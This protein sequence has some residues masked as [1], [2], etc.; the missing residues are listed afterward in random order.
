MTAYTPQELAQAL[1]RCASEPIHQ[2][3]RIQPHGAMIVVDA[4]ADLR[5]LQ[6]SANL[7]SLL[8]LSE[9]EIPG[10]ALA[11]LLGEPAAAAVRSLVAASEGRHASHGALDVPSAG[12]LQARVFPADGHYALE[13]VSVAPGESPEDAAADIVRLQ[14]AL[15][16]IEEEHDPVRYLERIAG[17]VREASGFDRVMVYRFDA[18]WDGEVVAE[19]R[20]EGV[21]SYLGTRFPASDIP[22]QARRL[23]TQNRFRLVADVESQPVPLVPA[24]DPATGQPTDLTFSL[25][26]SFSPVHVEYLRNMGVKASMSISLLQ[27]GRLWGLVACHHMSTRNLSAAAQDTATRISQIASSRLS[28]LE[29]R[30]R[31]GLGEQ[32][33][34]TVG[35]LLKNINV[36]SEGAVLDLMKDRLLRLFD[37]TGLIVVIEGQV[38]A[39]GETPGRPAIDALLGWLGS[40][41]PEEVLACDDLSRRH[42]PAEAYIGTASGIMASP[43]TTGM[44][45]CMVWLRP[46]RLRAVRWAGNPEK[47]LEVDYAGHFQLSPRKSF[48]TWTENWRGRSDSWTVP[49]TEAAAIL[50]RALTEGMA[51]KAR[52]DQAREA[53]REVEHRYSLA[54]QA[55]NDGIW[56]WSVRAGTMIV[57]PAFGEMLGYAPDELG[58][59]FDELLPALLHPDERETVLAAIERQ[60]RET[61][62]HELEFRLRRRDGGYA[63]ILSRGT[64]LERD[65]AGSPAR[66]IGT[67]VDL[68]M[69]KR[70]EAELREA[71]D[72]AEAANL[73]KSHFL[74]NMS[75][76]LRTPLNGMIGL[77]ELA[78]RQVPEPKARDQ[79][80]RALQL[81]HQLS[82]LVNDILDVSRLESE[83]LVLETV[84]FDLEEALADVAS[85]T[86]QRAAA[87][88]LAF[89][90]DVAPAL[91]GRRFTGDPLRIGQVVGC[92]A[93]NGVKFTEQG[94][95][96]LRVR[97]ADDR[98]TAL[99][100]R[101]EVEDTGIG[102]APGDA[103]R[104]FSLFEQGDG[105]ST[106]K[107]GGTG[108]GL[109]LGKRL[110]DLMGG[111]IGVTSEEGKGSLFWFTVPLGVA[112]PV[113]PGAA[114]AAAGAAEIA[115]IGRAEG[116]P[117]SGGH[118][119][120]GPVDVPRLQE[121]CST[122]LPMIEAGEVRAQEFI[123][124]NGELLRSASPADFQQLRRALRRFD[125]EQAERLLRA[126][127]ERHGLGAGHG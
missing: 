45:N 87:K 77:T 37:A 33:G 1:E 102:I 3:G 68:T 105:S 92:L 83:R 97:L 4:G 116:A 107:H 54:L 112:Q 119:A 55:T 67:H 13:L 125:F 72:R 58:Q 127:M 78:R 117:E 11:A 120:A 19:S 95:V 34:E 49:V 73:A 115:P 82:R 80:G 35:L 7:A 29:A 86:E 50:S 126:A 124:A 62:R 104:V 70:M 113:A 91:R 26:R 109:L 44:R 74:A 10:V 59:R 61:G 6:A 101:F 90:L 17:L 22:P 122:L 12:R 110:V 24:L 81:A 36:E 48:E 53:Q 32:V 96:A 14:R 9:R 98:V 114:P 64:V 31:Q 71:K 8:G 39:L 75:H 88:G 99:T 42:P 51:Q 89:T 108:L 21:A 40:L 94:H 28:A 41:P 65:E 76:E 47:T 84:P 85:D 56:E 66:A 30:Q 5:I 52:L 60:L 79:L 121:V 25:L 69:R 93:G 15:L 20:G 23:Y 100:L 43:V 46:E 2:I 38:H 111:E 18:N 57:N 106:R 118:P 27:N 123:D 63:W 16:R 103:G